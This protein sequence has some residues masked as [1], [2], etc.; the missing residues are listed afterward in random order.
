MKNTKNLLYLFLLF[1]FINLAIATFVAS[2]EVNV[3]DGFIKLWSD[4][5][6]KATIYDFYNNQLL[7]FLWM[8]YK[9]K[10][11]ITILT[12]LLL[13]ISFG[14]FLSIIYILFYLYKEKNIKNL[15]CNTKRDYDR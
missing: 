2:S 13:S 10:N 8:V 4:A 5:W 6:F 14:S 1:A 12:L 7:I 9:E 11:P 3:V 15:I